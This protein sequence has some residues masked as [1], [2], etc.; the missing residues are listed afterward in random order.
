MG[1]AARVKEELRAVLPPTLFFFVMLHIVAIIRVLMV[2]G[3]GLSVNTQLQVTVAA[4][5]LG[6][7][8][9]VADILPFINRYPENPLIDNAAWKTVI[10]LLV[11]TLVHYLERLTD[12]WRQSDSLAA[13]YRKMVSEIVWP[14]FLAIEII[15]ILLIVMYNTMHE[16]ARVVGRDKLVEMFFGP[17]RTT[18]R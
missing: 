8:V 2:K 9:L 17:V 14:H 10:Y 15:L 18:R 16:L 4:L 13:G 3:T 5:I 6:K 7:A 12:F 1:L 11:A